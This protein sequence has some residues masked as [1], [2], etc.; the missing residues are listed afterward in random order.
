M[1]KIDFKSIAKASRDELFKM[2]ESLRGE[3]V[4]HLSTTD[5]IMNLAYLLEVNRELT[6]SEG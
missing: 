4:E 6:R 5:Q 3:L 1:E 2:E